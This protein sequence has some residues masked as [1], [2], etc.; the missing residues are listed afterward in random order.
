MALF[1]RSIILRLCQ[2]LAIVMVGLAPL[3]AEA[4]AGK[5]T[6]KQGA[7]WPSG[8]AEIVI[9]GASYAKGW[10]PE[11][12]AGLKVINHGAGGE[13]S[14]EIMA[15]FDKDIVTRK[16][17]AVIIWGFINDIF[18][19]KPE[20]IDAKLNRTRENLA[21]MVS[22]AQ[23]RGI[24]PILTTEVVLPIPDGWMDR[25]MGWVGSLRGKKSQ[26]EY[27]NGYVVEVNRWIRQ[28]AADHKLALLDFEKVLADEGGGR[29]KEY[30][31][32]D[33]THL[34]EQAYAALTRYVRQQNL[35]I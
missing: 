24:V 33:G 11:T 31:T 25:L 34:S 7:A 17:R 8:S 23:K 13:Q 1:D 26:Q 22:T 4:A 35:G 29:K 30:T 3:V 6:G 27:V 32:Q 20:E 2:F 28:Y 21:S 18:R 15:R 16:P 9:I 14:H 19:S 5:T 10:K 12:I